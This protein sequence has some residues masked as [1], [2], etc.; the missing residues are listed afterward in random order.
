MVWIPKP[1]SG[2][3]G[4]FVGEGPVSLPT[5]PS[6]NIASSQTGTAVGND[7]Y[8]GT[9]AA[10]PL[11][12]VAGNARD[13]RDRAIR[14]AAAAEGWGQE[15]APGPGA[16]PPGPVPPGPSGPSRRTSVLRGG[17]G[18]GGGA[19][20]GQVTPEQKAAYEA[21]YKTMGNTGMYDDYYNTMEGI[22][23]VDATKELYDPQII[24][25]MYG[26]LADR[27]VARYDEARGQVQSASQAGQE[28]LGTGY[29]AL[30]DRASRGR[31]ATSQS[32]D[33][34]DTRLQDVMSRFG[35][36]SAADAGEMNRVAAAWDAGP[37]AESGA[38]DL[39]NLFANAQ[40]ANARMG[41]VYDAAFADRDEIYGALNQDVLSGMS[42]EEQGLLNRIAMQQ[43][44]QGAQI[45]FQMADA[46]RGNNISRQGAV[47]GDQT[48][49]ADAALGRKTGIQG[50]VQDQARI[51][52]E[53]AQLGIPVP[54][55]LLGLAQAERGG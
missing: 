32:F 19:G 25:D 13:H 39:Q 21:L 38:G 2:G 47:R 14:A 8:M 48:A 51:A 15:P 50:S 34:A 53:M 49:L 54:P 20:L 16:P 7:F 29:Q 55:E 30:L 5:A 44:D 27:N 33:Q 22:Y 46:L 31:T 40:I 6:G 36:Q 3:R 12:S 37:V 28:R 9:T 1:A 41:G 10:T 26:G 17:G 24:E 45:D 43:A 52:L 35:G 42:R 4:G 18:G 23:D 11:S